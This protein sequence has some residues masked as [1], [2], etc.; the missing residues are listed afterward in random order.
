M[1]LLYFIIVALLTILLVGSVSFWPCFSGWLSRSAQSSREF[2]TGCSFTLMIAVLA[3]LLY[4]AIGTPKVLTQPWISEPAGEQ[5]LEQLLQEIEKN[6]VE[7]PTNTEGWMM[8]ARGQ[9]MLPDYV[10]AIDSLEKALALDATNVEVMIRL[11]DARTM[12]NNGRVGDKELGILHNAYNID[13]Q[14]HSLLWLLAVAYEQRNQLS[15]ALGYW[16]ELAGLPSEDIEMTQQIQAQIERLS[17]PQ[18]SY[19]LTVTLDPALS[20]KVQPDATLF[21]FASELHGSPMPIAATRR[22][23][24]DIPLTIQLDNNTS[25]S[26]ERPLSSFDQLTITA[27]ISNAGEPLPQTG[28]LFGS[29]SLSSAQAGTAQ[30]IEINSV[31]K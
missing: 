26:A 23:A 14:N 1:T 12:N 28:D 7:N 22:Q 29:I 19:L 16:Q 18:V 5:Q 20:K 31:Y 11:A 8:L 6:L 10:K 30:Q 2:I 9:M 24:E 4:L 27:R 15:Q 13:S 17:L 21:I 3:T 25:L